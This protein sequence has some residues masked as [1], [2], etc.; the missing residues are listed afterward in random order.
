MLPAGDPGSAEFFACTE[1]VKPPDPDC[2]W[3]NLLEPAPVLCQ[4]S[5]H[6]HYLL[7]NEKIRGLSQ[8]FSC[9]G[10]KMRQL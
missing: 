7:L 8:A 3:L 9:N 5:L 4:A 10:T 2:R 6:W 1:L